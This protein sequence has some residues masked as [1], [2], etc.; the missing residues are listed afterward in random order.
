MN[1]SKFN[2][3]DVEKLV[4][5]YEKKGFKCELSTT[6]PH[7]NWTSEDKG[8]EADEIYILLEGELEFGLQGKTYRPNIGEVF[9]V[10]AHQ[11]HTFKNPGNTV[12]RYY[13]IY[14]YEWEDG[15][16]GNRQ[17]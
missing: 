8:H 15:V 4:A 1:N 16:T 9:T 3:E 14:D 17:D 13:W 7:E 10:P 12:S 11:P 5:E 6:S 2:I